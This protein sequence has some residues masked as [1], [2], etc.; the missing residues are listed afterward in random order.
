MKRLLAVTMITMVCSS[1]AYA[2]RSASIETPTIHT[3]AAT[4]LKDDYP[5]RV[6]GKNQNLI[7]QRLKQKNG[8]RSASIE[9]PTIHTAAA[10]KLKD[11]YPE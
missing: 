3:A 8:A 2:V 7:N 11:D 1:G 6:Q 4:K 9:T 5:E 10:T